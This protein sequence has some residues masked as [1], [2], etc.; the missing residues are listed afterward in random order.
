MVCSAE[1]RRSAR[2]PIDWPVSMWHPQ[3]N[4][5]VNGRSVNISKGGA[6]ITLPPTA[7]LQCGQ[8]VELNFPRTEKLAREIGQYSRVKTAQVVRLRHENSTLS[9][10]LSVAVK[11]IEHVP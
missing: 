5:F 9:P 2:S 3:T 11:F 8:I 1:Q 6:L 4:R 7:S 10:K